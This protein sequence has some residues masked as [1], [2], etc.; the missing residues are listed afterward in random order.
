MKKIY[1]DM[2]GT[3]AALFY[4]KN[5]REQ[6]TDHNAEPFRVCKPLLSVTA[7]SEQINRLQTEGYTIG[8]ITYATMEEDNTS[9]WFNEVK[10]AKL[11][12]LKK[13]LGK[14]T[15]DEVHIVSHNIP[16]YSLGEGILFDDSRKNRE[17]WNSAKTENIAYAPKQ[18]FEIL[19]SL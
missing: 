15:F 10:E 6:V 13:W 9:E 8:V 4:V 18:I 14:V 12:W 5:W 7:L 3:I 1:F 11:F 16:K 2:D 17:E 19:K